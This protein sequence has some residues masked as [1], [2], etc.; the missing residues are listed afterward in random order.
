MLLVVLLHFTLA[1]MGQELL[2]FLLGGA[3]LIIG[4]SIFLLGADIGMVP[5]GQRAGSALTRKRSLPL[6]MAASFVIGF[7]VTI[8]E[9]DVQVLA[10]QV[11]DAVPSIDKAALVR[12]IAIG[13]GLFL[14]TG[15]ARTVLQIPLRFLLIF[16][17]GLVFLVCAFI[18]PVFVGIAFDAS[19]ATTGPITVP[20]IMAIGL[21]V[22]SAAGKN[23]EGDDSSF[24]LV[25]MAS[26]G[27]IAAVAL[28]GLFG[29][30][31]AES[32]A[33]ASGHP[34]SLPVL[35][36]FLDILPEVV[37]ETSLALLPLVCIFF[38]FQFLLLRL[39]A[40]QVKRMLL[41]LFYTFIGLIIFMVGVKGGFSPAGRVLGEALGGIA[42][43]WV[44]I[45]VGLLL[46]AVV[47]CAEPA[48]WV[49]TEQVEQVSG[50][51]IRR[52]I[53]L[54]ALSISIAAAVAIGMFRVITGLSIWWVL[55]PGYA[56]ALALTLVCPRLF[57]AIAF[58]SGGVASGPMS[59]TFVLSLTL[60]ASWATGGNPT[61]DA[62]GMI[63]MIAMAPLITIQ[64]LGLLFARKEK[65]RKK[66]EQKRK[67][68]VNA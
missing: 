29:G 54:A 39:S 55:L 67:G 19:G 9:P 30:S 45:P 49:L 41:G 16:F 17:Y 48:V 21:G 56:A 12:M 59:A 11:H 6:I 25:G 26:I 62:F 61:T 52:S 34:E 2:P 35:Q 44:L 58:D 53:M 47:V 10:L 46:G 51:H 23:R 42:G 37:H 14:L 50:G 20:F 13:V 38:L 66:L 15:T 27:P 60:G 7:A 65:R 43:G 68:E 1:P 63:A 33:A 8:A 22:A 24:G 5:F 40:S 31:M 18:D 28:M 64:I 3:L 57:T 36:R 32:G 4:L